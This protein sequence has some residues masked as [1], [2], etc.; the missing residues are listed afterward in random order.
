MPAI[1]T[2]VIGLIISVLFIY[3]LVGYAVGYE[4]SNNVTVNATL[5]T[6]Y[7]YIVGNIANPGFSGGNTT[8]FGAVNVL[9]TNTTFQQNQIGALGTLINSISIVLSFFKSIPN[10]FTA[11]FSFI[12]LPLSNYLHIPFFYAQ[13]LVLGIVGSL[14]ALAILSAIF[15][16]PT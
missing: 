1:R 7:N 3:A 14:L 15:L 5:Q 6:Q 16:F 8:V 2:L 4:L 9:N 10:I 12:S 11:M 13:M